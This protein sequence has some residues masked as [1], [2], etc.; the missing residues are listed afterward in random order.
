MWKLYFDSPFSCT[1]RYFYVILFHDR[2][3]IVMAKIYPWPLLENCHGVLDMRKLLSIM[4]LFILLTG[5]SNQEVTE[6]KN[7]E[8]ISYVSSINNEEC[9]LCGDAEDH[10][11]SWYLGQ[12]NLGLV[13][14]NTFDIRL[15]EINRYDDQGILLEEATGCMT[16]GGMELGESSAH[17]TTDVDRGYSHVDV[18]PSKNEIDADSIGDYLCQDC[19]DAF[20]DEFFEHDS[21]PEV[22]IINFSTREIRPLVETCTWFTFDNYCVDCRFED[23][24]DISL[25]IY[26]RPVRYHE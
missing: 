17:A 3:V 15:I 16:M 1:K 12:D 5:C 10:R 20:S 14:V 19:L 24:G 4:F 22:A 13:N 11:M 25:R 6:E 23:D 2:K 9:L 8:H 21:P 18:H 7:Y 26:Y